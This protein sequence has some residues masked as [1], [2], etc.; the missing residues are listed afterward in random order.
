MKVISRII[1]VILFI[2]FF[3][4]ALKNTDPV[5]LH[6][7]MGYEFPGPLVLMLLIFFV[8]GIAFGVFAMIPTL[9][10]HRRDLSKYKKELVIKE[11][12][13]QKLQTENSRPPQPDSV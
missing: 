3:G 1:A 4:F 7:F 5:T 10:R 9:F 6:F 12:E 11:Q 8:A 13:I 2:V